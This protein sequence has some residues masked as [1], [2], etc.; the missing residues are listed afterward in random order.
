V[1]LMR[2]RHYE[3]V[4]GF[5]PQKINMLWAVAFPSPQDDLRYALS[6]V[7]G[8]GERK[9]G[10]EGPQPGDLLL[11]TLRGYQPARY[12]TAVLTAWARAQHEQ[13]VW[14][15]LQ[16]TRM[17]LEL[18]A[19]VIGEYRSK[20]EPPNPAHTAPLSFTPLVSNRTMRGKVNVALDGV[21]F[22]QWD[23][24]EARGHAMHVLEVAAMTPC[25]QAYFES[26]SG[27]GLSGIGVPPPDEQQLMVAHAAIAELG[28]H[29]DSAARLDGWDK[30]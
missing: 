25:D 4:L 18:A 2:P 27:Q 24:D 20:Q 29:M 12:A 14:A 26:I 9:P 10:K 11:C 19:H 16:S 28:E 13:A 15:Q 17:T 3:D 1:V 8:M 7:A 23:L 21:E 22:G 30:D 6:I 5:D